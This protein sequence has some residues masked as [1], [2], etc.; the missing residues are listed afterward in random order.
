MTI[1]TG[2]GTDPFSYGDDV[3][4]A[5]VSVDV[6]PE[7][8][9]NL[10]SIIRGVSELRT[11]MEA[12][13]RANSSVVDYLREMPTLLSQVGE[14]SG[15]Y[16]DS[17][18]IGSGGSPN[19]RVPL[20][21]RNDP[22][23]A[24][25]SDASLGSGGGRGGLTAADE[26]VIRDFNDLQERDPRQAANMQAQRSQGSRRNAGARPSAPS[27]PGSGRPRNRP[28]SPAPEHDADPES[29]GEGS[30]DD[31]N[32]VDTR[33]N[34]LPGT[35]D[36]APSVD[37]LARAQRLGTQGQN[38]LNQVLAE[39]RQGQSGLGNTNAAIRGVRTS[40]TAANSF[41]ERRAL[42][43]HI[44]EG[45]TAE[46]FRGAAAAGGRMGAVSAGL[47]TAAKFAGAAGVAYMAVDASQKIGEQYQQY[48][49]QGM[50]RGGG[51]QEGMG[52]EMQIRTM[53]MNPF[54]NTEQSRKVINTALSEG[55]T[56]K[57]FDTVTKFMSEN[58]KDMNLSVADSVKLLNTNVN[59]GGQSISQL[60]TQLN[61]MK[62]LAGG[63]YA[64]LQDRQEIYAKVSGQAVEQGA[65]GEQAGDFGTLAGEYLSDNK[66]LA[67]IGGDFAS[68]LQS[69]PNAQRG[70]RAEYE[71][72]RGISPQDVVSTA[73]AENGGDSTAVFK[74][75]M[76]GV[77]TAFQQRFAPMYA[78]A[79]SEGD[80]GRINR[81][82]LNFFN[83]NG[84]NLGQNVQKAAELAALALKG[85]LV[86]G[87]DE[88]ASEIKGVE[89]EVTD[90]KNSDFT[91]ATG[92]RD[93]KTNAKSLSGMLGT[94][95]SALNDTVG[96][97]GNLF[98][99]NGLGDKGYE[100]TANRGRQASRD[101]ENTDARYKNTRIQ[102]LVSQYGSDDI[103]VEG[104]EGIGGDLDQNNKE[105]ME[106]IA[107]GQAKVKIGGGQAMTISEAEAAAKSDANGQGG[108]TTTRV[109]L[110]L[111]PLAKKFVQG[112]GNGG[113][114]NT[115]YN[116]DN[117]VAGARDASPTPAEQAPR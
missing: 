85:E 88:A 34:Q 43:A 58:L 97:I 102:G 86:S 68:S 94:V 84:F 32:F 51:A 104:G 12:T 95:G 47:G 83:Q 67:G 46:S 75:G 35:R 106:A 48:K 77:Q 44:A 65:S 90:T 73:L 33:S 93:A 91:A 28:D 26:S 107:K 53:A 11:N 66:M 38:V 69:N 18:V 30:P 22:T 23:A 39:T 96:V 76:E 45:G 80:R 114:T 105:Q 60:N 8:A 9:A 98:T 111:T 17:V 55:Y 116:A 50:I 81:Q 54:I 24:G 89:E 31:Y 64:T 49:N 108:N 25:A 27:R 99:G 6:P 79:K 113:R 82:A 20:S 37:P 19:P 74:A 101:F 63:G 1:P 40:A 10:D 59:E 72:T 56:G 103:T 29:N 71:Q 3:V 7:S 78:N 62:E 4:A 110:D 15:R 5:R 52:Y 2:G 112:M 70:I 57:E 92:L 61:T 41:I 13:A 42:A 21:G 100:D 109:E 14:A 36:T 117:G 87:V 115:Q 16:Q